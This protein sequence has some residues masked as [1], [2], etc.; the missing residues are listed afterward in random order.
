MKDETSPTRPLSQALYSPPH[1]S[2]PIVHNSTSKAA[3]VAYINENDIWEP[4]DEFL[5][6]GFVGRRAKVTAGHR[7]RLNGSENKTI[8]RLGCAELMAP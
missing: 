2:T 8:W 6:S 4:A 3:A 5:P 1:A 7:P